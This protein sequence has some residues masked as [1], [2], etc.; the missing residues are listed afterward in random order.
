MASAG[1]FS[2]GSTPAASTST[3]GLFGTKPA[4]GGLFGTTPAATAAPGTASTGFSF[5]STAVKPL[6]TA[7]ASVAS[8]G[9]SFGGAAATAATTTAS[10][11][12][13]LGG[14]GAAAPSAAA[15]SGTSLF[16][17]FKP[18]ATTASTGLFGSTATT[19][20]FGAKTTAA[21]TGGLFSATT[22]ATSTAAQAKPLENP[23]EANVPA[24]LIALVTD[25][26]THIKSQKVVKEEISK[27][28]TEGINIAREEIDTLKQSIALIAN[29]LQRDSIAVEN[30]K[31]EVGQELK[32]A[33]IAQ[34][35]KDIAVGL[36]H[37]FSAPT[38]YF[39]RLVYSFENRINIYRREIEEL[40]TFI[41]SSVSSYQF[42]PQDLSNVLKRL[43][44]S[45]VGLASE[46][47]EVHESVKVIKEKYLHFR[48][49]VYND[50]YDPFG[51]RKKQSAQVNKGNLVGP[52]PFPVVQ[53]AGIMAS[54]FTAEPKPTTVGFN[55]LSGIFS[56]KPAGT[57]LTRSLSFGSSSAKPTSFG[58]FGT[59][60]GFGGSSLFGKTPTTNTLS[61]GAT[62]STASPFTL[63][64]PPS[65]KRGKLF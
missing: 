34:R 23:K 47:Q 48:R 5:G 56:A 57:G 35:I 28:S 58:G 55:N 7:T 65:G 13:S 60:S 25:L 31:L 39:Q 64:K 8:T 62:T 53:G 33:E 29:S 54:A 3:G 14:F 22:A 38:E 49:V 40:E 24:E 11:G 16:S 59:S 1:G 63:Q 27:I 32:N 10:T 9:F 37:D 43:N 15:T 2:F 21:A 41:S 61:F 36:H 51:A 17:G 45:F 12:F 52:S 26:E 44:D 6:G 18:A 19:G 46:L 50:S 42:T 4:T 20:L 30:L